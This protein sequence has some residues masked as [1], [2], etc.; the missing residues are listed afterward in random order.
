MGLHNVGLGLAVGFAVATVI[1]IATNRTPESRDF[2]QI[3]GVDKES[4]LHPLHF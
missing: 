3:Y 2:P 1:A 4:F